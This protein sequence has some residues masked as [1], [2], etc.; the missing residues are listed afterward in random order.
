MTL[1]GMRAKGSF[2]T[3]DFRFGMSAVLW[4]DDWHGIAADAL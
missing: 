1:S 3:A 4:H 2:S